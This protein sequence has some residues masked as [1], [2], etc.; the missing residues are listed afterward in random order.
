MV[1]YAFFFHHLD[2]NKPLLVGTD[3]LQLPAP[4]TLPVHLQDIEYVSP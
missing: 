4:T 1:R 3:T 2:F